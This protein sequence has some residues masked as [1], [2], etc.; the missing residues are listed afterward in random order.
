MRS[1]GDTVAER[2]VA[3][4]RHAVPEWR[5]PRDHLERRRKGRDRKERPGEEEHREDDEPE[6]RDERHHRFR[7]CRPRRERRRERQPHEDGDRDREHPERRVDCAESGDDEE[8]DRR[9]QKESEREERLVAEHDVSHA[10]RARQHRVVLPVPLDRGEHREG[11]FERRELH[12]RRG[13]ETGSDEL[14]VGDTGGKVRRAVD[15]DSEPDTEGEQV[16]D[17]RDDARHCGAAPH[18]L[19]LREE[20][21]ERSEGECD[22]AH[23]MRL[24]P[25]RCR[26]TSSSVLRRTR[27]ASGTRPRSCR[28]CDAASPSSVYSSTRSGSDSTRLTRPSVQ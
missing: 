27:T 20:E 28:P 14:E 2:Q 11:R 23:S 18:A 9:R 12:C 17:R 3:T 16:D 7:A 24:R 4:E 6:D 25:V 13:H 26:K 22:R 5:E 8:V 15:E 1:S 21:L 19:V 10:Q